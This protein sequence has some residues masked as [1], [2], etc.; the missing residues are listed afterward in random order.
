MTNTKISEILKTKGS[1]VFTVDASDDIQSCAQQMVERKVGALIVTSGKGASRRI[2]GI[3]SE[4]DLLGHLGVRDCPPE[5]A[6]VSD[7]MTR[8]VV[9]VLPT[10]TVQE[11]MAI[12]TTK[13]C[14]HLPVVDQEQI[15]GLISIGDLVKQAASDH[16]AEIHYLTEYILGN[17]PAVEHRGSGIFTAIGTA[18]PPA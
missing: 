11:A 18:A 6:K 15:V 9:A 1:D 8:D 12:M 3:V 2:S 17:Y 7:I 13:R 10:N 14:R 5:D 16:R 4:R